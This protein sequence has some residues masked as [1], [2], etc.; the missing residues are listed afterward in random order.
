MVFGERFEIVNVRE[1]NEFP[2]PRFCEPKTL[3][4]LGVVPISNQP[5]VGEPFGFTEPFNVADVCPIFVALNVVT[6]GTPL[7]GGGGV[8]VPPLVVK[9]RMLP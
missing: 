2:F 5:V 4:R 3:P 8:G 6:R 9:E 1:L 7:E